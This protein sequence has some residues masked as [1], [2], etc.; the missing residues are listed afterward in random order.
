MLSLIHISDQI[1]VLDEGGRVAQIGTHAELYSQADG[2]YRAFWDARSRA[3]G[4]K[5]V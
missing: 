4:W 3:S 5:L 1:V 2:Q